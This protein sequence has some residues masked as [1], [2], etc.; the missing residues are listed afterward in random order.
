[1]T[2]HS[3]RGLTLP[4]LL[5]A[6][7]IFA[8]I[9]GASVYALRLSVEGRDQLEEADAAIRDMQ[10]ARLIIKQDL[11]T[12][13]LRTVRDEFG[14]PAPAPFLG[15]AG[16]AL[17]KPVEGETLLLAFVRR[18][19]ENPGD[20]APRPSLQA[21]E[22]LVVAD[23]VVR[24]VRPYLDDASG[25]PRTDRVLFSDVTSVKIGFYAGEVSGRI[26]WADLWPQGCAGALCP[27]PEAV[28]LTMTT[29]RFGELEQLFWIGE[30]E[31]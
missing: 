13:A 26:N 19:W 3:Q 31:P 22:Y 25:Q 10:I 14:V 6:L 9:S 4:E 24:R 5:I 28:Q 1:M 11:A 17:R 7:L 18:G 27:P 12:V 23:K 8:M 2:R 21:V 15:G 30:I 20:V 16:L 29:A